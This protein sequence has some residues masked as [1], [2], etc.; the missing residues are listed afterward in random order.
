[1]PAPWLMPMR[2]PGPSALW[3]CKGEL[4]NAADGRLMDWS[5]A[6]YM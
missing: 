1:M 3:G 4:F 5:Y 2:V 6:G